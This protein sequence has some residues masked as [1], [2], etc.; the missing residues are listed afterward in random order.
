MEDFEV[1]GGGGVVERKREEEALVPDGLGGA[2]VVGFG[3][4]AAVRIDP[5]DGVGFEVAVTPVDVLQM[6]G[7]DDRDFE[8]ELLRRG[9]RGR[10]RWPWAV[11]A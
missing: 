6:L 11:A 8:V 10:H 1:E 9:T 4:E 5:E 7:G 2:G 3:G